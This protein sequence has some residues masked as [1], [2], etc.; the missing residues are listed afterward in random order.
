[1]RKLSF[2]KYKSSFKVLL[3][4]CIHIFAQQ[5][6]QQRLVYPASIS[7]RRLMEGN[8]AYDQ[9]CKCCDTT[10]DPTLRHVRVDSRVE[11]SL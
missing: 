8:W 7:V 10:L 3:Y 6:V 2:W 1:M 9:V 5:L 4:V 11:Q